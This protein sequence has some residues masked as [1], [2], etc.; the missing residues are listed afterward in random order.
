MNKSGDDAATVT[1]DNDADCEH[2]DES[3]DRWKSSFVRSSS[4]RSFVR[5]FRKLLIC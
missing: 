1:N 2:D 3:D 4:F 5:S